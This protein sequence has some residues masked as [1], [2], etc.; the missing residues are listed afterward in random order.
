MCFAT[1]FPLGHPA[2]LRVGEP[3]L[4]RGARAAVPHQLDQRTARVAAA[5]GRRRSSSSAACCRCC[6]CAGW[7]CAIGSRKSPGRARPSA[8][9]RE[10]PG[11]C[12]RPADVDGPVPPEALLES[13][14]ALLLLAIA[15]GL[16][17]GPDRQRAT[18]DTT[19]TGLGRPSASGSGSSR[20]APRRDRPLPPRL[21]APARPGGGGSHGHW[22]SPPSR[23]P[24]LLLHGLALVLTAL[25]GQWLLATFIATQRWLK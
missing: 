18:A 10:Y 24:V 14:Y 16:D 22:P 12:A 1:L 20:P 17:S 4:L 25:V 15:V 8:L 3:R 2:A 11:R 21:R 5:A 19:L 13:G 7:A 9:H 23:G 6:I